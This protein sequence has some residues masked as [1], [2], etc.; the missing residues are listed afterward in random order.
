MSRARMVTI[1][2]AVVVVILAA[3]YFAVQSYLSAPLLTEEDVAQMRAAVAAQNEDAF[4]H[5]KVQPAAYTD[6][7][8]LRNV[9]F[10]ELHTH[11]RLSFDAYLFGNRLSVDQAYRFARGEAVPSPTGEI[12]QLTRPLDFA[13]ITDHAEG[14]GMMEA[15]DD[16]ARNEATTA[17]C[18]S[19]E[20]P[21]TQ[22]FLQLRRQGTK[23]P[24][25][26]DLTEAVKDAEKEAAYVEAPWAHIVG[27]AEQHNDPGRFTAFAGYEYSPPLEGTGKIHRNVIFRNG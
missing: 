7:N 6:R 4:V 8:D 22:F 3:G 5:P 17:L 10:G 27:M 25:V 16:P 18:D 11:S 15:C 23:R 14:F 20:Q 9:Y 13:A 19:I 24:P 26:S 12:M 2:G 21:S 1:A